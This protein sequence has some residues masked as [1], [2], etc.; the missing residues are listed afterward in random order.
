MRASPGRVMLIL[1]T[2]VV[3]PATHGA[4]TLRSSFTFPEAASPEA[5]RAACERRALAASE[6]PAAACVH[7]KRP[8]LAELYA[9]ANVRRTVGQAEGGQVAAG[10]LG[11][12]FMGG[13]WALDFFVNT[14]GTTTAIRGDYGPSIL[15]PGAGGSFNAGL[16]EGRRLIG[17]SDNRRRF[18]VRG[19]ASVSAGRWQPT[20]TLRSPVGF[21][22]TG[23]GGGGF[24][25]IGGRVPAEVVDKSDGSTKPG[26]KS[27]SAVLDVGAAYRSVG[28]D[29]SDAQSRDTNLVKLR[30]EIGLATMR[31]WAPEIG[32]TIAFNDLK[33]GITWYRFG[34]RMRGFSRG[35][36]VAGISVQ[37]AL[38]SGLLNP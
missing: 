33:A 20:D 3:A 21:V 10:S 31:R 15:A 17:D 6:N 1:L 37:S 34:G 11:A 26:F 16:I 38:A 24:F 7:S 35:Q 5:I 8:I 14:V 25:S 27:L 29:I 4:Q 22:G 28:G 18:G 32:V 13:T 23:L 30:D 9:D 19:Y 36:V 2:G 12:F